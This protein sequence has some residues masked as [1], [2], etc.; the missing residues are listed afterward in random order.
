MFWNVLETLNSV[1][2]NVDINLQD[3]RT[4]QKALNLSMVVLDGTGSL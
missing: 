4:P 2:K 3:F 1:P